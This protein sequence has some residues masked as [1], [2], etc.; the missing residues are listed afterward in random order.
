MGKTYKSGIGTSGQRRSPIAPT[1]TNPGLP[2]GVRGSDP[3]SAPER[4]KLIRKGN[5]KGGE[6][7]GGMKANRVQ[8]YERHGAR[9]RIQVKTG[10]QNQ[11]EAAATQANGR[12]IP[13]YPKLQDQWSGSNFWSA[14][15]GGG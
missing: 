5:S 9:Q 8:S 10:Y 2:Q 7:A 14:G 3:S 15:Q 1:N 11:P 12:I 6:P 13:S 4:G